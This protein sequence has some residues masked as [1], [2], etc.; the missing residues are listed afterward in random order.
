MARL[1]GA[2][3]P[4]RRSLTPYIENGGFWHTEIPDAAKYYKMANMAYQDFAVEM[5]FFDS[6]Q[7]YD[8]QIYSEVLQKFRLAA[9]GPW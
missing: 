9:E 4:I 6:P 2:D 1:K 3:H 8:F 5:G 7:P